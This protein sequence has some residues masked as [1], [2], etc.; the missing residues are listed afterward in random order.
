[1]PNPLSVY[2]PLASL[3]QPTVASIISAALRYDKPDWNNS[4]HTLR[5]FLLALNEKLN[6]IEKSKDTEYDEFDERTIQHAAEVRKWCIKVDHETDQSVELDWHKIRQAYNWIAGQKGDEMAK[7]FRVSDPK[8]Y[9]EMTVLAVS[10]DM[11]MFAYCST[12][13]NDALYRILR[14]G[15]IRTKSSRRGQNQSPSRRSRRT[16]S[17]KFC[18]MCPSAIL[19]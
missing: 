16:L 19:W 2:V 1:M 14:L 15:V 7:Y 18:P 13:V 6:E 11:F 10:W 12:Y 5:A 4:R 9:Y 8:P 17:K 3:T